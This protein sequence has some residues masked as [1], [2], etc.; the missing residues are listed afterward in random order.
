M[1]KIDLSEIGLIYFV[2]TK[3]SVIIEKSFKLDNTITTHK[4]SPYFLVSN[5]ATHI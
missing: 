1:D 5:V 3:L 4:F 2:I